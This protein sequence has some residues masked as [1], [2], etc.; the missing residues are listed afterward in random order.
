MSNLAQALKDWHEIVEDTFFL[1]E[2]A[3]SRE[4]TELLLSELDDKFYS[5]E[6]KDKE[7]AV[8][9]LAV[10]CVYHHYVEGSFWR[11]FSRYCPCALEKEIQN[12]LGEYIEIFLNSY[13]KI[14]KRDFAFRTHSYKYV[15]H[16]V[17]ECGVNLAYMEKF[18]NFIK[19]FG[20]HND[21]KKFQSLTFEEYANRVPSAFPHFFYNFLK[22]ES[23]WRF[24]RD[25]ARTLDQYFRRVL[26][27]DNLCSL[28][29]YHSD[30]WP[31]FLQYFDPDAAGELKRKLKNR[32]SAWRNFDN[33]NHVRGWSPDWNYTRSGQP[34]FSLGD[35]TPERVPHLALSDCKYIYFKPFGNLRIFNSES[36]VSGSWIIVAKINGKEKAVSQTLL[37][38][39]EEGTF[40]NLD[41]LIGTQAAKI[42]LWSEPVGRLG[43]DTANSSRSVWQCAL[44]DKFAIALEPDDL[45]MPESEA[46]VR[47]EGPQNYSLGFPHPARRLSERE[48]SIPVWAAPTG[49][50]QA[51]D[52][53]FDLEVPVHADVARINT[54]SKILCAPYDFQTNIVIEGK[55]GSELKLVAKNEQGEFPFSSVEGGFFFGESGQLEISIENYLM[56]ELEALSASW[57]LISQ[58]TGTLAG[59]LVYIDLRRLLRDLK[60]LHNYPSMFF[61][62][63]PEG[64][65][66]I[67][68]NLASICAG[69]LCE[70]FD[71]HRLKKLDH[72]LASIGAL[73][74]AGS[75]ILENVP[76]NGLD[77]KILELLSQATIKVLQWHKRA[78]N[79]DAH[80][81]KARLEALLAEE[82]NPEVV[83]VPEW[84]EKV[85]EERGRIENLKD[86]L[87]NPE[88]IIVAWIREIL[89]PHDKNQYE[90]HI[91]RMDGG[92]KLTQHWRDFLRKRG[93]PNKLRGINEG[94]LSLFAKSEMVG[95][96]ARILQSLIL[97]ESGHENQ[98]DIDIKSLPEILRP[99]A[100]KIVDDSLQCNSILD[101][102]L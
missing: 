19:A 49:K 12:T 31:E 70:P 100:E 20:L 78:R 22:K 39:N 2:I 4:E 42:E 98:I 14:R 92:Q 54:G 36:V 30:F 44:L 61:R 64:S 91:A 97:R 88:K 95:A 60:N 41:E 89:G 25:V 69:K 43:V 65:G 90:S 102:L 52:L 1:G 66:E 62:A 58:G 17:E 75:A 28:R 56:D 13:R 24:C 80:S 34:R 23:G 63:L 40:L 57:A 5:L 11:P 84:I 48:W 101:P 83:F 29:G 47:L 27:S 3:L 16:I 33:Q 74:A 86:I 76:I 32:K 18:A 87:D 59:A 85:R 35:N 77:D 71:A 99:V 15:R 46:R 50:L 53:E 26:N 7:L 73:C 51:G 68:Q 82:I 38:Q 94:L 79:A 37:K 10:N 72:K 81:D 9:V 55:P 6:R 96:L 21:F 8:T 93:Q 45:A 67:L